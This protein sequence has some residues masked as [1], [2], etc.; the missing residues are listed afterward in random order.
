MRIVG[1]RK[2]CL[3]NLV[4][5]LAQ[6]D[7]LAEW[8]KAPD[9]GS[10]PKGRGFKSHSCHII[11]T[12]FFVFSFCDK[13]RRPKVGTTQMKIEIEN[14]AAN[15]NKTLFFRPKLNVSGAKPAQPTC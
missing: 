15:G 5:A 3:R 6:K 1:E 11:V 4:A 10:G 8:S 2:I 12:I 13:R 7:S 9:L 14:E